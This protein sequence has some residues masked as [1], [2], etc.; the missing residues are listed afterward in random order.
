MFAVCSISSYWAP[1]W[2]IWFCYEQTAGHDSATFLQNYCNNDYFQYWQCFVFYGPNLLYLH[3][4]SKVSS[5][6]RTCP[7]S[8][9]QTGF[10]LM[11]ISKKTTSVRFTTTQHNVIFLCLST[12]HFMNVKFIN[13]QV[14]A[15]KIITF[16]GMYSEFSLQQQ[17]AKPY[18]TYYTTHQ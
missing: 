4:V 16:L 10:Y 3:I 17:H 11:P 5:A 13:V 7:V 12:H 18:V 8:G 1:V 9:T 2:P 14:N 15:R 6:H